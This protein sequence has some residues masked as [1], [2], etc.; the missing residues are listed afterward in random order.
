MSECFAPLSHLT[1][2]MNFN[3]GELLII[4]STKDYVG[5]WSILHDI[6]YTYSGNIEALEARKQTIKLIEEL[7]SEGLVKAGTFDEKARFEFWDLSVR[8]TIAR[9]ESE[10]DALV[11]KPSIGDIVWFVATEK[12]KREAEKL[13]K[14]K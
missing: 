5:L 11:R 12:G 3:T 14:Q 10:W 7:L 6:F 1:V 4:E 13:L 8:E 9:I 2:I